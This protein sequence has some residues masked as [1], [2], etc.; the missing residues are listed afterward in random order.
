MFT[1]SGFAGDAA[2]LLLLRW[3]NG[4]RLHDGSRQNSFGIEV[5]GLEMGRDVSLFVFCKLGI[6]IEGSRT[7]RAMVI[8]NI[9]MCFP[10]VVQ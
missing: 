6:I 3:L 1:A 9:E 8:L 2:R 4:A 7:L 10:V 5:G